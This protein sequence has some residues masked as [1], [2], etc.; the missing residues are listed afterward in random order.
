MPLEGKQLR[1]G[2][3][4]WRSPNCVSNLLSMA[5]PD[6]SEVY[7]GNS[8]GNWDSERLRVWSKTDHSLHSKLRHIISSPNKLLL[9]F[10]AINTF[11]LNRWKLR[12]FHSSTWTSYLN[13]FDVCCVSTGKGVIRHWSLMFRWM[14]Q[15]YCRYSTNRYKRSHQWWD[16]DVCS[17]QHI[18]A[19]FGSH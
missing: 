1:L 14:F 11:F 12:V 10:G 17:A 8:E 18:F 5:L 15:D 7:L 13:I 16:K 2:S 9:P 4:G 19:K 6:P 3:P